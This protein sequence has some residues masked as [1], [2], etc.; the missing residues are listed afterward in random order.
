MTAFLLKATSPCI[1]KG[2]DLKTLYQMDPGTHDF[3]GHAIPAGLTFDIG[4]C[5]YLRQ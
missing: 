3:F 5:E 4:A 1:D 2:L